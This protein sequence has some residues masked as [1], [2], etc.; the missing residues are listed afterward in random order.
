MSRVGVAIALVTA[1]A[2]SGIGCSHPGPALRQPTVVLAPS[3]GSGETRVKV[4]LARTASEQQRGMMFRDHFEPG[5]GML[6]L[7]DHP[8]QMKFWMH[9]CYIP[10]DMVFIRSDRRVLGVVE[11][12]QPMTD[13]SRYVDGDSQF[14]LELPGG[15]AAAHHIGPGTAATFLDVE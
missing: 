6:F 5:W 11:R 9:N 10:I 15:F 12:A 7:F 14:V 2:A 3:D 13:D 8:E 1:G 4:E